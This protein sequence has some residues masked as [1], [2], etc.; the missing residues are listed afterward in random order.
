MIAFALSAAALR[1]LPL[2]WLHPLNYDE[3]EFFRATDWVRRGLVP[4]RDFWQNH[5]P[6]QWYLFAPVS[7]LAGGDGVAPVIFMRWIQVPLWIAAFW[8]LN[9]WMRDL[10]L[11]PLPR[12]TALALALASSW[13]MIPAV[14]YRLDTVGAVLYLAGLAIALRTGDRWWNAA[15]GAALFL[16]VFA[17]LR[18]GPLVAVTVPLLSVARVR[19]R[20]WR[21]NRSSLWIAAGGAAAAAV[22]FGGF[23]VAGALDE[24]YRQV[25]IDNYL[26]DRLVA[27]QPRQFLARLLIPFGLLLRGTQP[28]FAAT[29]VDPGGIALLVLG[30]VGMVRALR[31]WRAPDTWFLVAILQLVNVAFIARMKV[32]YNYHFVVVALLMVPFVARELAR[33][34]RQ[35]AVWATVAAAWCMNAFASVARGKELDR[36]YQDLII[37]EVHRRTLP[38]ESVFSGAALALRRDPAYELWVLVDLTTLLVEHGHVRPYPVADLLRKPPAAIISDY[39]TLRYLGLDRAF[40]RAAV[41]HYLPLWRNLWVPAPNGRL[42]PNEPVT[43]TALRDG[44]YRVYAAPSLANHPWFRR[45]VFV[46]IL[47]RPDV[48]QFPIQVGSPR[49]PPELQ[50]SVDGARVTAPR[51]ALKKGQKLTATWVGTGPAGVLLLPG[52]DTL[53]FRN[54]PRGVTLEAAYPRVTHWPDLGAKLLAE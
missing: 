47:E 31:S 38:S 8:L 41:T 42:L 54:P 26:G 32:V 33:I 17:N 44:E 46:G 40:R 18:L 9:R 19:E 45:P 35:E 27:E 25:W 53:W 5:T 14:E 21:G 11:P 6:L 3:V 49:V 43:W 22:C 36:A 39:N 50:V 51:I 20:S 4:Y 48:D 52:S 37:K 29:A 7:G 15:A 10:E 2:G 30:T 34:R 16:S 23:A 1:L 28:L 13:V 12:W 24:L